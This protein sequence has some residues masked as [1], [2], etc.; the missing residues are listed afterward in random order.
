MEKPPP[1]PGSTPS[2]DSRA[3]ACVRIRRHLE[4]G[5]PWDACD[6]FREEAANF[7]RD[8][9]LLYLG[10]LAHA[11]AGA[12]LRARVLLDEAQASA[13]DA[14]H[15]L[16]D[17]LSLRGRLCKD[18]F[19]RAPDA[20][21]ASALAERARQEYLAAYALDGDP[22][23]GINAAT[24]SLLLGDSGAAKTLAREVVA[25]LGK[26]PAPLSCWDHAA[27]GE[28]QLVLGDFEQATQSYASGCAQIPGDAGS[29]AT[30]RRQLHLLARVIP[31]AVDALRQLP[32]PDVVAFAGHLIDAPGRAVPRFPPALAPEVEAAMR[33][34][35]AGLHTPIIYASAACGADLM[36][37]ELA[38]EAGSEVNVV[39]PFDRED[40]VRTSVAVG[41][42]GWV[43]RFDA[44][45]ARASRVIMATDEGYLGD[46]VLFEHAAMLLEGFAILR[47]RQLQT[48][49]SLYCVID[50]A[51]AGGVGGTQ[52]S[53][54]RWKSRVGPP[55]V[56][57]LRELRAKLASGGAGAT[58]GVQRP[59]TVAA[60][61]SLSE[62]RAGLAAS[63]LP[64]RP[65]R[66]LKTL[67]FAD[68]TG[69]SR[70]HDAVAPLF[71][72]SFWRIAAGQIEAAPVKPL[73]ASTW[74]DALYVVFDAPRAAAAFALSFLESML[75]VD[76]MA[77]G[78]SDASPIRISLH[79]G[80]VF[81]GFDPI[82]GRDNYF[83]SSVTKAARIEPV[84]P[85]GLVYT[86]EAFAATLAATGC[87]E[88]ALE[89][90]G[91]LALAKGYGESRIYRLGRR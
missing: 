41:G 28:A 34:Q 44:A 33:E 63:I 18:E 4:Q 31:E 77:I 81:C 73:M 79:A 75:E 86:S 12:S 60:A 9:E 39:L 71:Q 64:P 57:D 90:M 58:R 20:L 24:L 65:Q 46:D 29:V 23:P 80:P 7:P 49:P 11:R 45:L 91:R 87:D 54:E 47:A 78:L 68:F 32:A 38:L 55:R 2:G 27:L 40:F 21:G 26:Q 51:S 14:R 17:I 36:F 67:L 19:H 22:Y 52:A 85:P 16:V 53:F 25:K 30:M 82:M 50:P 76:W 35:L 13:G 43:E 70:V 83:G 10:A 8:P 3:K 62:A 69:F 89:Y 48:T 66:S 15:L 74:G 84:T 6:V 56:L 61:P 37:V 5:A 1:G 42:D 88:Y 59:T 72:E